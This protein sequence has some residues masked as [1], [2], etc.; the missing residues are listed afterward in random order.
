MGL[1]D[2]VN[3]AK[4]AL[5]GEEAAEDKID[6]AANLLKDKA[7]D[8][9]DATIDKVADAAKAKIDTNGQ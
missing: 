6:Q 2:I 8:Q 9:Y 5:G 3:K 4:D 7:P 1:D